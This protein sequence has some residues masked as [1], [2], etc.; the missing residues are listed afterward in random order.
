MSHLRLDDVVLERRAPDG[1]IRRVIEGASARFEAGE[2]AV[3][4][5]PTGVGKST[6][7]KLLATLLR[8]TSGVVWADDAPVSRHV[9]L[10]RDRWRRDV[11]L[12]LQDPHLIDDLTVVENLVLPLVPRTRDAAGAEAKAR[13]ALERLDIGTLAASRA[14]ALSGGQRQRVALARALVGAPRFLLA[15][16]PTAHQDDAGVAVVLAAL[17]RAR[18]RAVVVVTAHDHRV[19]DGLPQARRWRLEAGRLEAQR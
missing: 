5:G 11:G 4:T 9:A 12:A 17:E 16:E 13:Q 10:H 18:E 3:I 7:V 6:L 14:G 8:P 2:I 1:S 19:L 15:D